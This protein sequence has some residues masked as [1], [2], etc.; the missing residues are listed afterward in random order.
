MSVSSQPRTALDPGGRPEERPPREQPARDTGPIAPLSSVNRAVAQSVVAPFASLGT[1]FLGA[2]AAVLCAIQGV[3]GLT[4]FGLHI[5]EY[6]SILPV[7]LAWLLYI[8]AFAVLNLSIA[9]KGENLSTR[10]FVTYLS[11]LALVA[12]L[13]FVAI[14]PLRDVG[15]YATA[16]VAAGFGLLNVVPLRPAREIFGAALVLLLGFVTVTVLDVRLTWDQVPHQII[17]IS[18]AVF[19]PIVALFILEKFRRVIRLD[20]D[21][22]LV[23]STISAPRFAVGMLASRELA[24]LDLT[25]EE[26]LESIADGTTPI[27]LPPET[28]S[29]AASLATELRLH[30]IEGRRETW[31]YHAVT[32]STHLGKSV[33]LMDTGSLAGLLVR[34]Q[35]DGLL[36]ALWLLVA[37]SAKQP[38][39]AE[40]VLGPVQTTGETPGRT[41]TFPIVITVPG[42]ERQKVDPPTWAAIGRVGLFSV[43]TADGPLVIDIQCVVPN[44]AA[45]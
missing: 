2:S 43:S 23:Q 31:L 24:R 19:P 38:T 45:Q 40:I 18:L 42:V 21:R 12:A 36:E 8:G 15:V 9:K 14:W 13:D 17:T 6:P 4:V 20:L 26:L 30:L 7:V 16:S 25:A 33:T 32:E 35:R 34:Q 28:A 1:A 41:V 10:M 5:S 44:P 11:T 39:P 27:P 29:T 37:D 22:V 3:W